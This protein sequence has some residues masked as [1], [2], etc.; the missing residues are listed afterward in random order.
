MADKHLIICYLHKILC[1]KGAEDFTEANDDQ[2]VSD[3][4][5]AKEE[6]RG[7]TDGQRGEGDEA[8]R[9]GGGDGRTGSG[10]EGGEAGRTEGAGQMR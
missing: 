7:G 3:H 1:A 9:R 2:L 10:A 6:G 4:T 5:M 8:M